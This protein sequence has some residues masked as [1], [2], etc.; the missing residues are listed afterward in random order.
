MKHSA[1]IALLTLLL[2]STTLLYGAERYSVS[3][4]EEGKMYF[5]MPCKLKGDAGT[6]LQYDMTLHTFRDSVSINMTLTA[7][8]G[9]VK[10]ISLTSG[11]NHYTTTQYELYFQEREGSKINTRIHIDC[12]MPEYGK[13]FTGNT[14]LTIEIDMEDGSNHSFTYKDKK[15]SKERG[16]VAEVLE[17]IAYN[18]RRPKS[19]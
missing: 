17:M 4:L 18:N 8:L 12:P 1:K 6:R 9:R 19:R 14:P 3:V 2:L 10:Q 7:S 13:L 5:F 11:E 15:W 16:F